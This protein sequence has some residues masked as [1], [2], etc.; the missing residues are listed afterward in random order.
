MTRHAMFDSTY[1]PAPGLFE[2]DETTSEICLQLC[3]GWSAD[4]IIAG[5]ED[6]GVPV[7]VFEEV[8]DE[9]ARFV[10][11]ASEDAKRIDA[12]RGALAKR[13]LSFSFDEGYDIGEAAE[14]GADAAREDGHK[15]YAYCTMQDVDSV[16]HTGELLFG[17]SSMAN[18]GDESDAEIG[19]AIVEALE[20]VGLS[21]EWNG[22]QAG[23]IQCEGLKFELP[24]ED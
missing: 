6:D 8:R 4:M 18:P 12:L 2:P 16:I 9:Y 23:R 10:P 3:H 24:L 20:E 5:L 22:K 17:F 1:P 21:P 15:G 19:Q 7:S 14:D 13:D 11:E